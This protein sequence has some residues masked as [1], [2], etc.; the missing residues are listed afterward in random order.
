MKDPAFLFYSKDWLVDTAEMMPD[1][2]GVYI[3]LLCYQ[4]QNGSIPSETIRI[5]K[6]VGLS[7]DEFEPIWKIISPKFHQTN[8][9]LVNHT[10]Q[11]IMTERADKGHK[12]TIIGTFASVLRKTDLNRTE[13]KEVKGLFRVDEFLSIP[14]E[15]LTERLTEWLQERLK[16]I[17]NGDGN[18][19]TNIDGMFSDFVKTINTLTGKKY[20]GDSKSKRQ[21]VARLKEGTTM[22]DF[23][24]AITNFVNDKYH[25]ET[26][27]KHLTPEFL[28]RADKIDRGLNLLDTIEQKAGFTLP[29][30]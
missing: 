12:N 7:A 3:D 22:L 19:S 18:E 9:R 21:F 13:Y 17:G 5:A 20:Q 29:T 26:G 1:E 16:S 27:F 2:K 28:S 10:L 4:H 30:N 11:R 8:D 23:E 25:I 14:T 6:L 24:K 15:C